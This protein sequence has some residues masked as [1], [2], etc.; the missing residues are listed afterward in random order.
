[1]KILSCTDGS[2]HSDKAMRW[3]A[4]F[5]INYKS[6]LEILYVDWESQKDG[7]K[8]VWF[9]PTKEKG[10]KILEEAKR[11]LDKEFPGLKVTTH[12][13]A[14]NADEAIIEFAAK[15]KVDNIVM[16]SR[17]LGQLQCLLLGC[18]AQKVSTHAP[19]P[20]TIVR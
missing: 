7:E 13:D 3:A 9:D 17:G 12:L 5:A 6:D 8:I 15:E 1:M 11:L 10:K 2:D 4:Q 20:V 14:G 18:I 19:C 16:G